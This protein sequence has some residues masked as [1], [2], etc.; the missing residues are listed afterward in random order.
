M[1]E[2]IMHL[3]RIIAIAIRYALEIP[4][5]F[6]RIFDLTFYPLMDIILWGFLSLWIQTGGSPQSS[7][8]GSLILLSLVFWMII[9]NA[10]REVALNL[11]EE[12]YAHNLVN[13]V[14]T[15]MKISEWLTAVVMLAL[16]RASFVFIFCSTAIMILRNINV[17]N[18]GMFLVAAFP[19]LFMSGIALGLGI[20]A[21]MMR[22][23]RRISTFV[24]SI[25]Y[26]VLSF[27]AVFYPLHLL[28]PW[29]Q[30]IGKLLPICY[31]FEALRTTVT[32]GV[33]PW[34]SLLISFGLNIFYLAGT[35]SLFIWMFNKSRDQGLAQVENY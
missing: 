34:S 35:M 28:P 22:W 31:V 17:L 30:S 29:A 12:L 27:S 16:I 5:D 3:Y 2:I 18:L 23:G 10:N 1:R 4:R 33:T 32:T 26:L 9:E 20:S 24:W 13:I 7:T 11:A 25:P 15:P 8:I 6:F 21:L 19:L 14:V